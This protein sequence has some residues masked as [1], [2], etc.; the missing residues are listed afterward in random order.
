ML[1]IYLRLTLL[2]ETTHVMDALATLQLYRGLIVTYEDQV[3]NMPIVLIQEADSRTRVRRHVKLSSRHIAFTCGQLIRQCLIRWESQDQKH[4]R[5]RSRLYPGFLD[6]ITTGMYNLRS[7]LKQKR[8]KYMQ[9]TLLPP[10][11]RKPNSVTCPHM[12]T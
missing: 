12:D 9:I 7:S 1:L 5:G 10:L 11:S 3:E 2:Y 6:D 4:L 8:P